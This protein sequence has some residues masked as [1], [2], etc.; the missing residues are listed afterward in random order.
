MTM[1]SAQERHI[2]TRDAKAIREEKVSLSPHAVDALAVQNSTM[3]KE[4]SRKELPSWWPINTVLPQDFT[5]TSLAKA[6]L[7][8][9]LGKQSFEYTSS[10]IEHYYYV[11]VREAQKQGRLDI[12][13]I[14]YHWY[15]AQFVID[16]LADRYP[17]SIRQYL[18]ASDLLHEPSFQDRSAFGSQCLEDISTG[19]IRMVLQACSKVMEKY[20]E[21]IQPLETLDGINSACNGFYE[22]VVQQLEYGMTTSGQKSLFDSMTLEDYYNFRS[23]NAGGEMG[24]LRQTFLMTL[25]DPKAS[26]NNDTAKL[27]ELAREV[28][29]NVAIVNDLYGLEKDR[30]TGDVNVLLKYEH[31]NRCTSEETMEWGKEE[32]Y[33]TVQWVQEY[34]KEYPNTLESKHGIAMA[35]IAG[36]HGTHDTSNRFRLPEGFSW[37]LTGANARS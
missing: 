17:L 29:K 19:K 33:R 21:M 4:P 3:F 10:W 20:H 18:E 34:R 32:L 8:E 7:P 26:F 16:Y 36:N 15:G 11:L 1:I 24:F 12:I 25:L 2:E 9:I 6:E 22:T 28:G 13:K 23:R 27:R 14:L 37:D 31:D 5:F 30:A 35:C